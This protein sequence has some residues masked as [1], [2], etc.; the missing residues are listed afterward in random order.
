VAA[1]AVVLVL[2]ASGTTNAPFIYFQ[3]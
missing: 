2:L 3:F 1:T